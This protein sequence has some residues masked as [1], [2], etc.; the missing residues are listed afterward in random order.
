MKTNG[1]VALVA[2]VALSLSSVAGYAQD[3]IEAFRAQ[4]VVG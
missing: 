4:R 3:D 2:F 1:F